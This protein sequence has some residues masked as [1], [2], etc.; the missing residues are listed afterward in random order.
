M[1]KEQAVRSASEQLKAIELWSRRTCYACVVCAA[2]TS[3]VALTAVIA[4]I[5]YSRLKSVVGQA[6]SALA[7]SAKPQPFRLP[8]N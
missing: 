4:L 6:Q 2:C 5:E 3:I 7:E 1:T 8:P